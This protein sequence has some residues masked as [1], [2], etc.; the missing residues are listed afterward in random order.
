M[1]KR[2]YI[3]DVVTTKFGRA[4]IKSIDLYSVS[5]MVGDP[6]SV[7]SEW[8]NL[9]NRGLLALDNATWGSGTEQRNK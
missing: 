5:P 4:R 6:L 1:K 9:T 3:N 8:K 2:L 7:K